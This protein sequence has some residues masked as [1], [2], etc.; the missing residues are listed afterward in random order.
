M[1]TPLHLLPADTSDSQKY[2]DRWMTDEGENLRENILQRIRQGA[3]EG[4]LTSDFQTSRL[5]FLENERDLKG[6]KVY[7]EAIDFPDGDNFQGIDF[8][9]AE[10][11]RAKFTN[12]LFYCVMSFTK[13][14]DC[15]FTKCTFSFNH[16]FAA[17]FKKVTFIDCDFI[18]NNTFTNCSFYETTFRNTF[19]SS[20]V[21]RDCLFDDMTIFTPHTFPEKPI[22]PTFKDI[23]LLNGDKSD[24]FRAISESYLSGHVSTKSRIY[25]FE[26]LKCLTR[27]NTENNREKFA[28]YLFEYLTGYGLRPLRVM[29]FIGGWFFS[30]WLLFASQVGFK[31]ALL[32]SCGAIFTFGAK[33]QLLDHMNFLFHFIY[34]FSSF[35]GISFTALFVTVLVNVFLTNK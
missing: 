2:K 28:G 13:F 1:F 34:I 20:N 26:H 25:K 6:L 29:A 35:I 27:Y 5:G 32:L 11:S 15:V 18:E 31:D 3:G 16:C 19:F 14:Y 24:L 23:E 8:S 12:A 22:N 30:V 10:F 17:M 33:A 9:Y 21:F 4:F 7:N